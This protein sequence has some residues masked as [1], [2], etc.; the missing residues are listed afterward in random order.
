MGAADWIPAAPPQ[1]FALIVMVILVTLI[2]VLLIPWLARRLQEARGYA[3]IALRS[4]GFYF[5][6][7]FTPES[8]PE[9]EAAEVEA[10]P[11]DVKPTVGLADNAGNGGGSP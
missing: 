8:Q 6:I 10:A 7:S 4:V 11:A 9:V 2:T 3:E 1:A 5:K